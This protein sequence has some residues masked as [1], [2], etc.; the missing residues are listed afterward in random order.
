GGRVEWGGG[1]ERD[2]LA[3]GGREEQ[4][5][6]PAVPEQMRRLD[7]LVERQAALRDPERLEILPVRE[8]VLGDR[9]S[10]DHPFRITGGRC[11]VGHEPAIWNI[12]GGHEERGAE[13]RSGGA[14]PP[15][16]RHHPAS[17]A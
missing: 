11:R 17:Y 1:G 13:T 5:P 4:V 14:V 9:Q 8:V 3:G 2:R 10:G 15:P 16:P 6:G 7:P 12:G